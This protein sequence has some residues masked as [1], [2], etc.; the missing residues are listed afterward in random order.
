MARLYNLCKICKSGTLQAYVN[1]YLLLSDHRLLTLSG[2]CL[3][4]EIADNQFRQLR[5]VVRLSVCE[6]VHKVYRRYSSDKWQQVGLHIIQIT[7]IIMS[8]CIRYSLTVP[9]RANDG[10]IF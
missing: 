2:E 9:R 10:T 5:A 6:G 7:S 1:I 4:A 8:I 3:K